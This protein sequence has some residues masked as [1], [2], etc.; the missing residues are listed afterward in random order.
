MKFIVLW[1]ISNSWIGGVSIGPTKYGELPNTAIVVP[2]IAVHHK[3]SEWKCQIFHSEEEADSFINDAPSQVK[4]IY[5][6]K[7]EEIRAEAKELSQ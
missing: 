5:K 7:L 4:F 3:S 6:G 2:A 1:M